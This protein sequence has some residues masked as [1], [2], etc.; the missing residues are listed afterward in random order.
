M[1]KTLKQ[2]QVKFGKTLYNVTYGKKDYILLAAKDTKEE[3]E[4]YVN[5]TSISS[6][7]FDEYIIVHLNN[8]N[9]WGVYAYKKARLGDFESYWR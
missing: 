8:T 7:I 1:V 9:E 4:K 2:S 3:A 6:S 5:Q